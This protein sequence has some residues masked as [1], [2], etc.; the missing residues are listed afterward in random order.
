MGG[1]LNTNTEIK[2]VH[3]WER[4]LFRS[5]QILKSQRFSDTVKCCSAEAELQL[6]FTVTTWPFKITQR[7]Y[8]FAEFVYEN[9]QILLL[10]N[11][12]ICYRLLT[13]QCEVNRNLSSREC[14]SGQVG[15]VLPAVTA[16]SPASY[17]DL[18]LSITAENA[19][20]FGGMKLVL[21]EGRE[22]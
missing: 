20:E 6:L 10:A 1:D 21:V 7:C 9:K 11:T 2:S 17:T 16:P 22:L 3:V 14:G 5:V 15:T 13:V 8:R 4:S 19:S 12:Y 18:G